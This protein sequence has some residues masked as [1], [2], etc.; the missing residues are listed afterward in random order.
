[1]SIEENLKRIA[2]A[3]ETGNVLTRELLSMKTTTVDPNGMTH[4]QNAIKEIDAMDQPTENAPAGQDHTVIMAGSPGV[5]EPAGTAAIEQGHPGLQTGPTVQESVIPVG[6]Q[7]AGVIQQPPATGAWDPTTAAI[8]G[9]YRT[10]D[11]KDALNSTIARLQIQASKSWSFAKKHQAILDHVA[12]FGAAAPAMSWADFSAKL[13][14]ATEV[15]GRDVVLQIVQDVEGHQVVAETN[16]KPEN[17]QTIL[18]LA[19]NPVTADPAAIAPVTGAAQPGPEVAG[20]TL[21]QPSNT[22]HAPTGAITTAE[23]LGE[24]AR[25]LILGGTDPMVVQQSIA[26]IAPGVMYVPAE[27]VQEALLAINTAAGKV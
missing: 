21:I 23:Q 18:D 15:V 12:Q 5:V 10:K 13:V 19:A 3:L 16:M 25:S 22:L 6:P 1:M 24:Y 8:Q 7:N 27:R 11:K 17:Y 26:H 9:S 14:A 20:Q 4:G 2:D